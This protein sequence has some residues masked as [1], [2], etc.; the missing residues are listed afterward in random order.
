MQSYLPPFIHFCGDTLIDQR[1]GK[2]YPTIKIGVQCWMQKNLNVGM[3]IS[4]SVNQANN[5]IL[6]KYCFNNDPANCE[7]YGGLYSWYEMMAYSNVT[8]LQG[9]CPLGWHIPSY[10]EWDTLVS[11]LGGSAV[12]G[13][14]MKEPGY[15]HWLLPN[16]GADNS[17]GFDA[18]GAGNSSGYSSLKKKLIFGVRIQSFH[19]YGAPLPEEFNLPIITQVRT[20]SLFPTR[21]VVLRFD[22]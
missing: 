11:F 3:M 16:T 2:R 18:I 13:G 8:L 9:I 22:A 15:T 17:S 10:S 5:G 21:I 7:I 14:K 6:E 1:D 19:P 12:A 4:G 20:S